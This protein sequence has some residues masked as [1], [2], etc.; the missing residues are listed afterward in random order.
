MGLGKKQASH[1]ENEL[2]LSL[3]VFA[4]VARNVSNLAGLVGFR[5]VAMRVPSPQSTRDHEV[6]KQRIAHRAPWSPSFIRK[7]SKSFSNYLRP[8]IRHHPENLA[9][10]L[11]TLPTQ[12]QVHFI[13]PRQAC[14]QNAPKN[15]LVGVLALA[16]I[17]LYQDETNIF[18]PDLILLSLHA[19]IPKK[20]IIF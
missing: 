19:K 17:I 12:R 14:G 1:H 9:R 20:Q 13:I 15:L 8:T 4:G 2:F 18:Y 3:L 11:S 16:Q 7:S 10:H 5:P 6:V